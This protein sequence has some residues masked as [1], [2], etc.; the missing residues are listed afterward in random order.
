MKTLL[1]LFSIFIT[2]ISVSVFAADKAKIDDFLSGKSD[3]GAIESMAKAEGQV[4]WYYWGGSEELNLWVD[5][6]VAPELAKKG[7]KLNPV[8]IKDTQEAID[9]VISEE[10]AGKGLGQGS[11]DLIWVNGDKFLSLVKAQA[12]LGPFADKLPNSRFYSFDPATPDGALNLFDF[13][14][15]TDKAEMPWSGEQYVCYAD[16]ARIKK[17]EIPTDFKGLAAYLKKNPGKFTYIAPPNYNGVTFVESA[18]RSLAPAELMQNFSKAPASK[19]NAN[20]LTPDTIEKMFRPGFE[21]LKSLEPYLTGG[22]K[23]KRGNP[24][25]PTDQKV[26]QSMFK[27]GEINMACEFGIYNVAV[28]INA[29]EFNKS[30]E[31]VLFPKKGMIKNRNFLVIPFNSPNPAAAMVLIDLLSS[32]EMQISKLKEIGFPAA[33]SADKMSAAQR[34]ALDKAAPVQALSAVDM[35]KE[36]A[37]EFNS[38]LVPIV[39]DLWEEFIRKNSDKKFGEVFRQVVKN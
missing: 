25:Y 36:A 26:L 30:V 19:D 27:S 13:G 31:P 29:G 35:E 17:N 16:T 22:G 11:A 18:I 39:R 37:P 34:Q 3:F 10:I 23:T 12:L 8:R 7:I 1:F 14:Q 28:K 32:P 21:Y 9:I 6:T 20:G 4:N 24:V 38:A 5:M 33:V 15:P 2:F